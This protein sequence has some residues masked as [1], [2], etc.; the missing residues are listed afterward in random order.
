MGKGNYAQVQ[1]LP[2]DIRTILA[3]KTSYIR[4]YSD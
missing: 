4:K 1:M 3:E 2:P